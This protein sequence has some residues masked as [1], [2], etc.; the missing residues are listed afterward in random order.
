MLQQQKQSSSRQDGEDEGTDPDNYTG[1]PNLLSI[2]Y[3]TTENLGYI[4]GAEG[5]LFSVEGDAV[6][7]KSQSETSQDLNDVNLVISGSLKRAFASGNNGASIY[8]SDAAKWTEISSAEGLPGNGSPTPR[9]IL[10]HD[11]RFFMVDGSSRKLYISTSPDSTWFETSRSMSSSLNPIGSSRAVVVEKTGGAT[12]VAVVAGGM[13]SNNHVVI[14]KN[15]DTTNSPVAIDLGSSAVAY[16]ATVN[17]GG[18]P[19]LYLAQSGSGD[20]KARQLAAGSESDFSAALN[21]PLGSGVQSLAASANGIYTISSGS[22]GTIYARV[23]DPN[24]SAALNVDPTVANQSWRTV[25]PVR[26][27]LSGLGVQAEA[28]YSVTNGVVLV[29]SDGK[30]HLITDTPGA[31]AVAAAPDNEIKIEPLNCPAAGITSASLVRDVSGSAS[32]LVVIVGDGA[33]IDPQVWRKTKGNDWEQYGDLSVIDDARHVASIGAKMVAIDSN[34][35]ACSTGTAFNTAIPNSALPVGTKISSVYNATKKEVYVAGQDG[36][37]YRGSVLNGGAKSILWN[38]ERYKESFIGSN[39]LMKVTGA[40]NKVFAAWEG[41][42]FNL[43]G[44][45]LDENSWTLIARNE[46]GSFPGVVKDVQALNETTVFFAGGNSLVKGVIDANANTILYTKQTGEGKPDALTGLSVLDENNIFGINGNSLYKFSS[47]S[48]DSWTVTGLGL[49]DPQSLNDVVAI[50]NEKVYVV[51]NNGYAA[52]YDGSKTTNLPAITGN[53]NLTSCWAYEGFLYATDD[54]G[55]VHTYNAETE[56]WSTETVRD[57]VA[58]ADISGSSAGQYL[59]AVGADSTSAREEIN[60]SGGGSKNNYVNPNN[61]DSAVVDSEVP[62]KRTPEVLAQN[63]GTPP[64]MAVVSDVQKFTTTGGVTSGSTHTFT[65]NFT[66]TSDYAYNE[67][68]LYKLKAD[69]TN[70]TYNRVSSAS[71]NPSSGDFWITTSVGGAIG[72]GDTLTAG[73]TYSVYFALADGSQ[74]DDDS[75]DGKITDPAVLGTSSG[76]SSGCVFNPTQTFGMEW[77]MLMFAPVAAF[78]RS[79]F[80]K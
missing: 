56:A 60:A 15:G 43:A 69:G 53:P 33:P 62:V 68:V 37:L 74:Y 36:L 2:E 76:G 23:D 16:L 31:N 13:T 41:S 30:L 20:L 79:R 67:V 44:K 49:L 4:S 47:P 21:T 32:D 63:Y 42:S 80:K 52:S 58:L 50:S 51:G 18:E 8:G 55:K 59:I 35:M 27:Y 70:L 40:G 14:Y 25:V 45:N 73:T 77:L 34:Q 72:A 3:S 64:D 46:A 57:G 6:L 24:G 12:Y 75:V 71:A 66:P 22:K 10:S 54:A 7:F 61:D 29:T 19:Y 9:I 5:S 17:H 28:L 26:D 38:Y 65:F 1:T 39:D 11:S 48:G 78:F